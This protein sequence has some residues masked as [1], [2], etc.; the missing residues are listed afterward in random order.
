MQHPREKCN[1]FQKVQHPPRKVQ[2][3]RESA[4]SSR[5]VQHFPESA[6]SSRKMQH[7]PESAT[8]SEKSATSSRKCNI[9]SVRV[10]KWLYLTLHC[11]TV[12]SVELR[13]PPPPPGSPLTHLVDAF[14]G[15]NSF[16]SDGST[17]LSSFGSNRPPHT[18]NLVSQSYIFQYLTLAPDLIKWLA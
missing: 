18:Q 4:T 14:S 11:K 9:C 10:V 3:P 2:H 6:T 1:I 13:N 17:P 16:S 8:S 5:K 7:F 15:V 12:F